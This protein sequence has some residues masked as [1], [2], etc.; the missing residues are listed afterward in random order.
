MPLTGDIYV[1]PS[2][3]VL[4]GDPGPPMGMGDLGVGTRVK[5][6]S[7]NCG[8]TVTDSGIAICSA[9]GTQQRPIQ[10]YRCRP[11]MTSSPSPK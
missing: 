11:H 5:I 1:V 2:N 7:A 3:I 10:R 4:E 8:Q 6:C 9:I